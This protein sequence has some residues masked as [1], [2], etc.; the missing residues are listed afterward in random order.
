MLIFAYVLFLGPIDPCSLLY[1]SGK[2][3]T[4]GVSESS[5][6]GRLRPAKALPQR[7]DGGSFQCQVPHWVPYYMSRAA[8]VYNPPP[9]FLH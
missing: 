2:P 1:C 4:A 3:Y 8:R 7:R 6:A 9:E 5:M